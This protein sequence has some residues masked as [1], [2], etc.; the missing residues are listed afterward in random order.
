[1]RKM[2]R[3]LEI[4]LLVTGG[5]LYVAAKVHFFFR[6]GSGDFV[7]EH[8]SL[9]AGMATVGIGLAVVDWL[10]TRFAGDDNH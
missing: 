1:M 8:W 3:T 2:F 5:L 10:K 6:Y 4:A 7:S 9:W